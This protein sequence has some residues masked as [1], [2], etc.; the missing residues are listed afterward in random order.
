MKKSA[1]IKTGLR[2]IRQS[3]TRFLSIMG[4]IF[5]GVMVFVGLKA[6]GP[7]MTQT[8]DNY[9]SKQKLSDGKI[10]SSLGLSDKDVQAVQNAAT[11]QV[12]PR[13]TAD[14]LV[15]DKNVGIKFIGKNLEAKDEL[16]EYVV[17][18]GRMPEK[19][20]EIALDSLV[21]E[22]GNYKLNE[23]LIVSDSDDK[24]NQLK[25][26]EFTIV[27]FIRSP[28]YIENIS[29]GNTTVGKGTLDYFAVIPEADMESTVYTEILYTFDK[30]KNEASYSEGYDKIRDKEVKSL[31]EQMKDR[32]QERRE[33]VKEAAAS[34][35][36]KAEQE[37][38]DGEKSLAD[39]QSQLAS[40]KA[41]LEAGKTAFETSQAEFL[42]RMTAAENEL[43][44]SQIQIDQSEAELSNQKIL[45]EQK[46][47]ELNELAPQIAAGQ[48]ALVQL[49][50]QRAELSSTSAVLQQQFDGYQTLTAAVTGLQLTAD[51]YFAAAVAQQAAGWQSTLAQLQANE[52][53]SAALQQLIANPVKENI[54]LFVAAVNPVIAGIQEQLNQAIAGLQTID[55]QI[56]LLNQQLARYNDGQQQLAAGEEQLQQAEYQLSAGK[57]QAAA[58]RAQLEQARSE[59]QAQLDEAQRQLV[60]GEAEYNEAAAEFEKQKKENEPKLLE[61]K[62]TLEEKKQELEELPEATYYYFSRED[63]PGYKEFKENANRIS[64]LAVV[65]PIFFFLIA[66]LVSLTTM[67]RMVE[68]KRTEIGSLKA[69]G[70]RDGE[71][72]FKFLLYGVVASLCGAVLGLAVGYYLFPVIIFDAYG[73]L[74]NIPDFVTPWYLGYSVFA[75]LLAVL[76]TVGASMLVLR[77]DLFSSPAVLLRPKAPKA[78]KR[79][80][81]ER[82]TP[83]WKRLSFIQKVTARNLFRY[84]QRM[85]MTVLGIAGCMSLIITGFGLRDSISDIVAVQY[86]KVWHY[87]AV[88]TKA[89]NHST[90]EEQ[91]YQ[92]ELKN[93]SNLKEAMPLHVETLETS[94]RGRQAAQD[95]MIYVPE[96]PTEVEQFITFA[97]RQTGEKYALTDDGVIINEKLSK[98]FGY[99]I[100]DDL[101]LKNADN[102]KF[103]FKI[104]GIAENYTG[105]FAYLTPTLYRQIIGKEPDYNTDFLLFDKQPSKKAEETIGSQLLALPGVLNVTFL[106]TS[107]KALN[108][109]VGSLTVVVWVLII[110]SGLL[111]F[112]VLYNLTNINVSERIRELSTV[113]VLGFYDQE[114]TMYVYRENIILTLLGILFG[115][116]LGK[117]VHRYVLETVE[118]DMLMFSP[119]IHWESYAYSALITA[120]FTLLV[121]ILMHVKLKKIDMIDALKSNE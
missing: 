106:S 109:T 43:T 2:E 20:G 26:R 5:L 89:E 94:H 10:V 119:T 93:S 114:V 54:G 96:K 95:V 41:E 56:G 6:T 22:R 99:K 85:L 36:I 60:S 17:T 91:A 42:N 31:K 66:A 78:G 25:T 35:L 121:M 90:E 68:E 105:H 46:K 40:S 9:F 55:G 61:A 57:A 58:G 111:A 12:L 98:L 88:V 44:A 72:A 49:Q 52:S 71:I 73:Q 115:S 102:Q 18:E 77:M 19:S 3:K 15:S 83:I 87:Q 13:H 23:R 27:G 16:I 86:N 63:N 100:G 118:V 107:S 120:F 116:L 48:T 51:E 59:G 24:D 33:E 64:S 28:E 39:A 103:Q 80:L 75:L 81:L 97:N 1:L 84:K 76:C 30:L 92:K 47:A 67:T 113:K 101:T 14:V 8:A 38:Q 74:Y 29:R 65:F 53:V 34:E 112:I 117:I 50:A 70:Y 32:P 62:Q 108:D 21:V 37:I 4:I 7:D 110:V 79:I 45:L 11:A 104:T 69:L 82:V